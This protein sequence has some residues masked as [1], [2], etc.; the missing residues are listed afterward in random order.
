MNE[1]LLTLRLIAE[2]IQTSERSIELMDTEG[3]IL[4]DEE[5]KELKMWVDY[6]TEAWKEQLEKLKETD[7]E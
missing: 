4:T 5:V 2:L 7:S 3:R 6:S 1:L